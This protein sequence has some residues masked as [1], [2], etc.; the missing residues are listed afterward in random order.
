MKV[1]DQIETR[2]QDG[3]APEP[4]SATVC[5]LQSLTK[6]IRMEPLFTGR[7]NKKSPGKS[8]K[9]KITIEAKRTPMK[10]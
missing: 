1:V 2:N 5:R 6:P 8:G 4:L 9:I 10:I 7:P 3:Q